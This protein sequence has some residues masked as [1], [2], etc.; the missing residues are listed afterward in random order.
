MQM[1]NTPSFIIFLVMA[2]KGRTIRKHMGVGRAKYKKIF[3]QG[4]TSNPKNIYELAWKKKF[5]AREMFT[6]N[7]QA[8][9]PHPSPVTFRMVRPD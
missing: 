4:T 6:K 8:A 5:N 3:Q 7:I 1:V 9:Q 2:I